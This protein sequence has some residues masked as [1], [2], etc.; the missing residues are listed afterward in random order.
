MG[1][2]CRRSDDSLSSDPIIPQMPHMIKR[3]SCSLET[4]PTRNPRVCVI[5]TCTLTDLTN[6]LRN[7]GCFS[8]LRRRYKFVEQMLCQTKFCGNHTHWRLD[9]G[10][11]PPHYRMVR[12]R[13]RREQPKSRIRLFSLHRDMTCC[14]EEKSVAGERLNF[15]GPMDRENGALRS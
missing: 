5:C 11:G 8:R 1:K 3:F 6:P 2:R 9:C 15:S 13:Q 7:Q 4:D 14:K 12:C 10:S